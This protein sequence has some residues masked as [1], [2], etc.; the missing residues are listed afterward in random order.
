MV[1]G[2]PWAKMQD[3]IQKITKAKRTGENQ[4]KDPC[5]HCFKEDVRTAKRHLKMPLS[6]TNHQG[7][8]N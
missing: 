7:N 3:P 5:S 8:V 6:A 2:L 4:P 1:G